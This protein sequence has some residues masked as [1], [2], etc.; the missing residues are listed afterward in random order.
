MNVIVT[1]RENI[2]KAKLGAYFAVML[3][4]TA[5]LSS[6][7]GRAWQE[8]HIVR[9]V[10][11][12][13][14]LIGL[15]LEEVSVL[16]FGVFIGLLT[17]MTIDPKKRWQ[18]VLLWLGTLISLFALQSMGLFLPEVNF[19]QSWQWLFGGV[20]AGVVTG[21]GKKLV[22]RN[23]PEAWEFRRAARYIYLFVFGVT[24]LA[25]LEYHI[26]YS[27][28]LL[29]TGSQ[30]A[31]VPPDQFQVTFVQ[32]NLAS[33][34]LVSGLFLVTLRQFVRYDA[35]QRFFVLGPRQSGKS[36]FLIGAYLQGLERSRTEE[37]HTPMNPSQDL[38]E[39]VEEL[40]RMNAD[41]LLESTNPGEV[42][43]LDFQYIHGT[44][45][46]KNVQLTGADYA[47]EWLN[48]LPDVLTE[49]VPLDETDDVLGALVTN[50]RAADTLIFLIDV[51]KFVDNEPLEISEYFSILQ[52]AKGK[53]VLLVATK[54]DHLA[55][56]FQQERGL[57]AHRYYDDFKEYVN[58]RLRQSEQVESLVSETAGSEIHPVYYQTRVNEDGERVPIRDENGSVTT[59][60]FDRL[61]EK[62]GRW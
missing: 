2:E 19:V 54:S 18:A 12:L 7:W 9:S 40:D 45:F 41:W 50:I 24:I 31:I 28:F 27:D 57:E 48:K 47:G 44:I 53:G 32:E 13:R 29:V 59:V 14:R 42:K 22:P 55:E 6:M 51:E 36:L 25:L 1:V 62:L 11:A 58:E 30:A 5:P 56:E 52:S 61:L 17:L 38:M 43:Q 23:N 34:I 46:P 10:L 35:E 16:V 8:A 60:G 21:G 39:M 26:R 49:A 3:V 37:S 4:L 15:T 33:H 20:V